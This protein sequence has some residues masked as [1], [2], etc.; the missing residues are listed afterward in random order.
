MIS[1]PYYTIEFTGT[2]SLRHARSFAPYV[3]MTV[4]DTYKL[5]KDYKERTIQFR[6]KEFVHTAAKLLA[7]QGGEVTVGFHEFESWTNDGSYQSPEAKKN[8][9]KNN[10]APR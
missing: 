5:L 7:D 4:T 8:W 3:G 9:V 2:V 10:S 1:E 6:D